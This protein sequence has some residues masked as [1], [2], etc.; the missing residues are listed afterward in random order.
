[1]ELRASDLE[2]L[3]SED[4][5]ARLVWG[6]VERQE[7]D[8][9]VRWAADAKSHGYAENMTPIA[10][11]GGVPVN[12]HALNDFR[13]GAGNDAVMDEVLSDNVAALAAVGAIALERVTQHG[14]RVPA[15]AGVA[16]FR[17]QARLEEH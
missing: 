8:R 7:P 9:T 10:I 5:R 16:S 15:D 2:S 4:H 11:C 14:M 6:Y 1:M 12:Y 13:S 3:L 17:R